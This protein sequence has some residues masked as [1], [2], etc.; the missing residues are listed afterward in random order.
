[1]KTVMENAK[2]A[3]YA[4]ASYETDIRLDTECDFSPIPLN[5]WT[6]YHLRLSAKNRFSPGILEN[7]VYQRLIF[8]LF[9]LSFKRVHR[10][11]CFSSTYK[12]CITPNGFRAY[13]KI[14]ILSSIKRVK[15]IK[16]KKTNCGKNE[17]QCNG[18]VS[19]TARIYTKINE[20]AIRRTV[21][22]RL[23]SI[24]IL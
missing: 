22:F 14:E 16:K 18:C 15:K 8:N 13:S 2:K 21:R 19:R 4:R 6:F 7:R 5:F 12:N 1:M 17:L 10:V 3:P 23:I 20:Y 11:S 9:P 24:R